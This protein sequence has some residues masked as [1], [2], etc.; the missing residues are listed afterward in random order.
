M[1]KISQS[2]L[3]ILAAAGCF[4]VANAGVIDFSAAPGGPFASYTE[5]GVTF[6]ASGGGGQIITQNTPNGTPGLLDNNSPR[7]E[8]RADIAG[9]A[10]S[11]S[12]DLGDFNADPDTIFLEIFNSANVSLGFASQAIDAAFTGMITLTLSDPDIAYAIFGGRAPAVNGSSIYADNFAWD[13]GAAVPEPASL[14]LL[15]LGLV[16]L[17]AVKRRRLS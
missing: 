15:G 4:G 7:K 12:V 11:V 14:A 16:G 3:A 13:A 1:K 2:A 8:L 5:Q 6:T 10:T 9:G 17:A